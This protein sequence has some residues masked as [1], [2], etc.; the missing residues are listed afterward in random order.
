M[1]GGRASSRPA[2]AS[3]TLS[4]DSNKP[5]R[6]IDHRG[7]QYIVH[8]GKQILLTLCGNRGLPHPCRS[9]RATFCTLVIALPLNPNCE[10]INLGPGLDSIFEIYTSL[11]HGSSLQTQLVTCVTAR[12][13]RRSYHIYEE[14]RTVVQALEFICLPHPCRS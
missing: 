14:P 11:L 2:W 8:L 9:S 7:L 10:A 12:A 4:Q 13:L 5:C 1:W 3:E 6:S